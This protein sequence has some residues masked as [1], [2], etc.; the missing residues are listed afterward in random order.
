MYMYT[1]WHIYIYI[2]V[3][4][5]YLYI[6]IYTWGHYI[7]E[8]M[9]ASRKPYQTSKCHGSGATSTSTRYSLTTTR[10]WMSMAPWN[11]S[12]AAQWCRFASRKARSGSHF[13]RPL[14]LR[15]GQNR[16]TGLGGMGKQL[17]KYWRSTSKS[18]SELAMHLKSHRFHRFPVS[19]RATDLTHTLS[20][21]RRSRKDAAAWS[22]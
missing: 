20:I 6:Y 22:L 11:S 17:L 9:Y 18:E 7:T 14:G 8:F 21:E 10:C 4:I 3:F 5:H 19:A 15:W 13:C 12:L 2:F 16:R 1:F